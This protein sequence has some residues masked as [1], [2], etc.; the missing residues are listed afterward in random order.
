LRILLKL[1]GAVPVATELI[2]IQFL[3]ARDII[4][5][6][7]RLS[8]VT[9]EDIARLLALA[10]RTSARLWRHCWRELRRAAFGTVAELHR[11]RLGD[12]PAQVGD[13]GV[14]RP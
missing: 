10:G 7:S 3:V 9:S 14:V 8:H 12:G 4:P 1:T 11:Q 2:G 13:P 6:I 5:T